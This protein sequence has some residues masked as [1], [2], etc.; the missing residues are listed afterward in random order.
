MATL[1]PEI[2][3]LAILQA[4][5][6]LRAYVECSDEIQAGIRNLLQILN[7]PN[8]DEDDRDMTLFTLADALFPDP[9]VGMLGMEVE[10]LETPG[11]GT[12]RKPA[13]RRWKWTGKRRRL[14][15]D[16]AMRW[17]RKGSLRNNWP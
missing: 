9:L 5:K 2:E 3:K 12:R 14:P 7:D 8:T 6:F 11:A 4:S 15:Q 10:D 16:C 13:P 1:T 17:I